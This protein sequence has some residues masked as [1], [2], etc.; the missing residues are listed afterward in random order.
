MHERADHRPAD[1]LPEACRIRQELVDAARARSVS[2]SHQ[3]SPDPMT[4]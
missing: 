2:S 1:A 3:P 4:T